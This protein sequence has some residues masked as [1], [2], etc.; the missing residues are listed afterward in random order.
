M[1]DFHTLNQRQPDALT[2]MAD[3]LEQGRAGGHLSHLHHR[4]QVIAALRRAAVQIE[5]ARTRSRQA[6]ELIFTEGWSFRVD[7]DMVEVKDRTG[8]LYSYGEELDRV[9][10]QMG[11]Y[12]DLMAEALTDAFIADTELYAVIRAARRDPNDRARPR[13]HRPPRSTSGTRVC[14]GHRRDRWPGC[15]SR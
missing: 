7:E 1:I 10:D 5:S 3:A 4:P 6:A 12:A 11:K 13:R 14:R 2:Q 9:E 15:W 8:R